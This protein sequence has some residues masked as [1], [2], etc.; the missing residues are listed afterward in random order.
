MSEEKKKDQPVFTVDQHKRIIS[1]M[2]GQLNQPSIN[3]R[4]AVACGFTLRTHLEYILLD[5]I[6][7]DQSPSALCDLLSRM[8]TAALQEMCQ[9]SGV[10]LSDHEALLDEQAVATEH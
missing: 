10:A 9:I 1:A 6:G 8:Q 5:S 4:P 2:L 7:G 3:L